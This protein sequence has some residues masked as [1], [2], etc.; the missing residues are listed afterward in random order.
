MIDYSDQT[1][2]FDPRTFSWPVHVIGLGGVGSA[3]FALLVKLGV[4]EVHVWDH[5]TVEPHNIPAQQLYR[6]RSDVG[7]SKV[8]AAC[9]Y[10]IRQEVDCNVVPHDEFVDSTTKLEGVVISG[11]DSMRS[12]KAIWDALKF[13]TLTPLYMDGRIGGEQW[14]L[15]T[16]NPSDF[17]QI[18]RYEQTLFSDEDASPLPCAARTVIHPPAVLTGHMVANL[19]LFARGMRPKESLSG[20]LRAMQYLVSAR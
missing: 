11:V 16:L 4:S 13:N 9:D 19:T 5:D 17:D 7:V 3:L 6:S 15:L 2:I 10:A 18:E 8:V 1:D 20:H 12:R 14:S